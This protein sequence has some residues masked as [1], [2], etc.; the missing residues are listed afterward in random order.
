MRC[1]WCKIGFGAVFIL[2]LGLAFTSQFI[3]PA[4][5]NHLTIATGSKEGAYYQYA[6]RYQELLKGEK[7]DLR[8]VPTKGSVEALQLLENKKVDVAFVQGGT[9]DTANIA[10]MMALGS[11]YFEPLWIFYKKP[12]DL[13]YIYDLKGKHLAIGG[14]GSGTRA[15]GLNL[16]HA[17]EV[18]AENT[19]F[20]PLSGKDGV[21][22]LKEGKVD[23]LFSVIAASSPRIVELLRDPTI[24]LMDMRRAQ[25]YG[26]RMHFLKDLTLGEG[27]LDLDENIP[28]KTLTLLGTTATLVADKDIHPDLIRLL[29]KEVKIVHGNSSTFATK[30]EFPTD[31]YTE[32]PM[33]KDASRYIQKGESFLER[34]FPFWIANTIDR[35]LILIIPLATLL[36]PLFKGAL[37]LYRWRIRS[38]IYKWYKFVRDIDLRIEKMSESEVKTSIEQIEELSLEVKKDSK[39][40]LSYMGEYYDLRMHMELIHERL[41]AKLKMLS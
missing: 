6:K 20:L 10:N 15:L 2:V 8:I 24:G 17:N 18:T 27:A 16:L 13:A 29:L 7:F 4:P 14:E 9:A 34:H 26:K 35:L 37:P 31:Q 38:K 22:A 33:S 11:I 19:T 39:I 23:A 25:A 5:P 28:S 30:G 36:I 41:E 3:D 12:M 32:I 40:P 21:N 1:E